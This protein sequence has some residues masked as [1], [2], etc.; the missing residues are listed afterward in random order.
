MDPDYAAAYADLYRTHWWWRA[1]EDLVTRVIGG[2]Q[3]ETSWR[4]ALDVGCGDALFLPALAQFADDVE[5]L[6]PDGSLISARAAQEYRIHVCELDSEFRPDGPYDL[7]TMLDV[8]E[9]LA[10]P[11]SALS[12]CREMLSPAGHLV[13]TVPALNSLWTSHDD[14]NRHQRRYTRR[15]LAREIEEAGL[16][17]IRSRYFFHWLVLPKWLIARGE[18]LS[19]SPL[20][21]VAAPPPRRNRALFRLSRLE[22]VLAGPFPGLPG[23]SVLALCSGTPS[24]AGTYAGP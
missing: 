1:R 5:G 20:H 3:R 22:Q 9:H 19:E 16:S 15:S 8:L 12:R 6:E 23:T 10:D 7:I 24:S 13:I 2:I 14:L 18:K 21:S 11:V 4:S 17:L